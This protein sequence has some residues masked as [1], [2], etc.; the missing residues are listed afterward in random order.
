MLIPGRERGNYPWARDLSVGQMNGLDVY[1]SHD[2]LKAAVLVCLLSVWVLVGLFSYLNLY[3]RRRYFSIWTAAWLFYALWLT[4]SSGFEGGMEPPLLQMFRQWCVGVSGVFLFWGGQRF[5][6][7]RVSQRL[8][9]WFLLFLLLWSY[10]S[11]FYLENPLQKEVPLF[12]LIGLASLSTARSFFKYRRKHGYVG[13]TLLI[14]GFLLW[15]MY[16]AGYPFLE[17]SKDLISVALF[18]SAAIQLLVAVSMIIL[19]LEE[20][21]SSRLTA[22]ERLHVCKLETG[23]LE[24]KVASTEERYRVLFEQASEAIII[25]DSEKLDILEINHAAERLLGISAQDAGGRSL[26]AFCQMKNRA[27]EQT[28]AAMFEDIR[29]E[30]LLHFVRKDGSSVQTEVDGAKIVFG[31]K[32]RYQFFIREVTERTR[33]EQQLRQAEKLSALGQMIS[34]VA[35]ELNNPLAV[36]KGSLELLLSR[37]ELTSQSR[38][39]VEKVASETDRAARLVRNFLS[40]AREQPSRRAIVNLNEIVQQVVDLRRFNFDLAGVRFQIELEQNLPQVSADPDQIQQ[41]VI[42]LIDNAFHAMADMSGRGRLKIQT[43]TAAKFVRLLVEDN[44]SG[45][46]EELVTK[47]FEPFFTTKEVGVGTG[48]GLSIAHTIMTDHKGRI[49]YQRSSLGGA[50]FVLEFPRSETKDAPAPNPVASKSE[51]AKPNH[52]PSGRILILDDEPLLAEM[53]AEI[54]D[55][56]GCSSTFC[57]SATEALK[58]LEKENFDLIISDF[59]M[60]GMNGQQFYEAVKQKK[61][62]VAQRIMF[63]TADMKSDEMQAFLRAT[64]NAHLEKPFTLNSVKQTVL[65][66]LAGEVAAANP[67]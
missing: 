33:L 35:H 67:A 20:V 26:T 9:G 18:I 44:G 46:P 58:L 29:R 7:E 24:T 57:H 63:M 13:A 59:K 8:V 17:N 41:V 61:P 32:A 55:L 5:L 51:P 40:F 11:A 34:G 39:T 21:R 66:A 56:I 65:E 38:D 1:L 22:I 37:N 43:R 42:N 49:S 45:V 62:E 54:L 27:P 28:G 23:A 31:G 14:L 2:Y 15:G 6:A 3:T 12:G 50:G 53:L 64:G 30:Q 47:I 25:T 16:M 60:P 48:L 52:L 36:I 19:V 4:L 10:A